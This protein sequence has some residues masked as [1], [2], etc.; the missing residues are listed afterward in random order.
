VYRIVFATAFLLAVSPAAVTQAQSLSVNAGADH[1]VGEGQQVSLTGNI[2]GG[3]DV[4]V[5]W[6]KLT[7]PGVVEFGHQQFHASFETGDVSEWIG[8][9]GGNHT[10]VSFVS[11]NNPRSGD[12]SWQAQNAAVRTNSNDISAKLLRW[13]FDYDEAYYSAWFYWPEDYD[14]VWQRPPTEDY[15]NMFQFKERARPWDPSI[16]LAAI[17][18]RWGDGTKDVLAIHDAGHGSSPGGFT[19]G[20]L[21][22]TAI[23]QGQWNH[24]IAYAEQSKSGRFVVWLNGQR[25]FDRSGLDFIL[26][27]NNAMWGIGNYGGDGINRH[28]FWDDASVAIAQPGIERTTATFSKPGTYRL[29]LTASSP[30]ATVHDEVVVTVGNVG[31]PPLGAPGQPKLVN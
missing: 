1:A 7:G 14:E 15:I 3:S 30:N 19:R 11:Q 29:R 16:L 28:L 20:D 24:L 27:S 8:D 26:G 12:W 25:I 17:P 10:G 5:F 31:S 9:D 23:P 6:S 22:A 18:D 13:R 2:A 21:N 4:Q